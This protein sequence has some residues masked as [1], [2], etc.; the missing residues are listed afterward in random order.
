MNKTVIAVPQMGN[1][2]FRKYMKGKYVK[3]IE[4]AG[5]TVRWIELD[6][7]TRAAAEASQCDGLLLPGGA[8]INPRLYG[9]EPSEKCG[10]PNTVRDSA[11]PIILKNFLD[12]GKPVLA[13]CRGIQLVNVFFGGT[14]LQD[15]KET[16]KYKH[17]DFL[18]RAHGVH[19]VQI[20]PASRL[21]D[22]VKS[23]EIKV[24]SMH[25]QAIDKV[26]EGLTVT[27]KSPDGFV[28][29]VEKPD[30]RFLAAVQWHP[31]HMSHRD[32]VQQAI[33]NRFISECE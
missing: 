29:A 6:D 14:L 1:D 7:I 26:G 15:I 30:Y 13:I 10:K 17:T 3:S 32:P 16:Q 2:L 11:E 24:N 8:D 5:G 31:E 33:F 22:I 25:H 12:T 27:A 19:G 23:T 21:Y 4:R 28:E 9:Q 20:E 18:G